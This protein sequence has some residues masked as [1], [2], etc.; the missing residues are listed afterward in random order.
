MSYSITA[1]GTR[2]TGDCCLVER[3]LGIQHGHWVSLIRR[4]QPPPCIVPRIATRLRPRLHATTHEMSRALLHQPPSRCNMKMHKECSLFCHSPYDSPMLSHPTPPAWSP[5]P[6]STCVHMDA[7]TLHMDMHMEAHALTRSHPA[8]W[9]LSGLGSSC[10]A[11]RGTDA[12]AV[13]AMLR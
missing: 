10:G 1:D 7:R 3:S 13:Y 4:P 11:V 6:P 12:A 9:Q 5:R 8:D 2:M